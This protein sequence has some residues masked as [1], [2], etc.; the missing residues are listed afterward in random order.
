MYLPDVP[1]RRITIEADV[2]LVI[3]IRWKCRELSPL[4]EG[5]KLAAGAGRRDVETPCLQESLQ[6]LPSIGARMHGR[7]WRWG[8]EGRESV[9]E[10]KGNCHSL[11]QEGSLGGCYRTGMRE[12]RDGSL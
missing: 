1:R 5:W 11:L 9:L 10:K 12:G 4:G 6:R 7:W 2:R 3:G 8:A